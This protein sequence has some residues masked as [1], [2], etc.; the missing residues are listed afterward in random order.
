MI[1]Q[2]LIN[3]KEKLAVIGLGYVGLPIALEF[4]RKLSY[5]FDIKPDRVELMKKGMDPSRELESEAFKGCDIQ[6]TYKLED[7]K[8][9]K[10]YI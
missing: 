4:A 9:A 10:L 5:G 7:I 8:A 3:K 2:D 1:Y 6:Y